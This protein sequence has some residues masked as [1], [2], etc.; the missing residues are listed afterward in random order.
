MLADN[1]ACPQRRILDIVSLRRL[2]QHQ[3]G[4]G[5]R[6]HLVSMMHLEDAQIEAGQRFYRLLH[7]RR[8]QIDAK[9]HVSRLDNDSVARGGADFGLIIVREPRRPDHM[10]DA[11]L[12]RE[13]RALD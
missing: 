6:I 11:R 4:A 12:G 8:E 3:R 1:G 9:A 10:N 5:R 13:R 2:A 7:Q